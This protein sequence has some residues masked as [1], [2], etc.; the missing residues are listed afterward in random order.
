[1]N[2]LMNP[3]ERFFNLT[4][5]L[6]FAKNVVFEILLSISRQAPQ[7]TSKEA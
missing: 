7:Y 1:M 5:Q 3:K 2:G 4:V 6:V